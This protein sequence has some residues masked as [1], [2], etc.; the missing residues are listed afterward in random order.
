MKKKVLIIVISVLFLLI[1]SVCIFW[2]Y[3]P[4]HF[5]YNDRF[6]FGSTQERIV[7]QYGSFDS[8]HTDA[9]GNVYMASYMILDDTPEMIMSYDN[10]L[11]YDIYFENGI[12]VR[13]QLR[14]GHI[15]G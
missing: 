12:A 3:H 7:A 2:Y 15:G 10:S 6:V 4:T 14:E 11:W 9:S 13:V 1:V 5:S 8:V